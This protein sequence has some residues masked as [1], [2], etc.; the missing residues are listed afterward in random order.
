MSQDAYKPVHA[1]LEDFFEFHTVEEAHSE[2]EDQLLTASIMN[3]WSY[4]E[5]SSLFG[6]EDEIQI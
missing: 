2:G 4:G 6:N 5:D 3:S 1:S